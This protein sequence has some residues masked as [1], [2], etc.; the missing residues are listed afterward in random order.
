VSPDDG[1]RKALGRGLSALFGEQ[2]AAPA[3]A[4]VPAA[5]GAPEAARGPRPIAIAEIRAGSRQPR[6]RFSDEAIDELAQSIRQHG[7]LQPILLRRVNGEGAAAYEIVAGER[8]W[9]AAQKAGLHEIPALVRDLT[10]TETL[11]AAL[12]E[13]VQRSDLNPIEEAEGYRALIQEFGH[14]QEAVA[15]AI[16]KSRSHIANLLRLL[17]LPPPV[18]ALLVEGTLTAGQARPLIGAPNA[19][20]LAQRVIAEG[21]SA[22]AV[23][24]L[25]AAAKA[26]GKAAGLPKRKGLA[27]DAD[28]RALERELTQTLG[29]VV[30]IAHKPGG[31]AGNL[32]IHYRTL[33]Q[34][35]DVMQKLGR[36]Q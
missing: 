14:T 26:E 4:P 15:T 6:R 36:S 22:R 32:T 13:N 30:E 17:E 1:K 34:L 3:A 2:A 16:G 27:K 24:K 9:R 18:R 31:Q 23:E 25:V 8:R 7:V 10:D 33:E 19:A 5:P 11:E 28:T 35:D 20:A 12:I 21:L 29:L